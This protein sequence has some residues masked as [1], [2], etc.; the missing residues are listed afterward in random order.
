MRPKR[1]FSIL[2][3][4]SLFACSPAEPEQLLADSPWTLAREEGRFV[5]V[6]GLQIFAITQ[7]A[8]ADIVLVHGMLDSTYTWRHVLPTLAESFRVHAID[9]PG[10]GFSEKPDSGYE[11]AWLADH[12]VGYLDAAGIERALLVG[13]SMGGNV[14]AEVAI[15]RPERVSGLVLLE[16]SGLRI[17]GDVSADLDAAASESESQPAS[18]VTGLLKSD[19]GTALVRILPTR[20]VLRAG[21]E[22]AYLSADEL[23]DERLD[24][25]H[26]PLQTHN[27]MTAYM[28]RNNRYPPLERDAAVAEIHAPTLIITGD[29]DAMVKIEVSRRYAELIPGSEFELWK[30]TG[31]MVQEQRPKRVIAAVRRWAA[32]SASA[33]ASASR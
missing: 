4:F 25:W 10:F 21:L 14:A 33:P 24:I 15:R 19:F 2:L 32:V 22:D 8:G 7:G 12:L 17:A 6:N 3:A 16:A 5:S 18:W 9:L 1:A 20:G 23:S 27:G 13:N 31:H 26:A 28:A 30:E 11:T 29:T